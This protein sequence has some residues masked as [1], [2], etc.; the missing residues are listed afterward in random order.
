VLNKDWIENRIP[1]QGNMCLLHRVIDWG[2]Q[3]IV[4]EG[5]SHRDKTNPLRSNGRLGSAIGVEYAAQAMAI[6][7][8]LLDNFA[9]APAVGYLTSL[10]GLTLFVDRLDDCSGP[11]QIFAKRLTGDSQLI[12]YQFE[13]HHQDRCLLEGRASVV[14]DVQTA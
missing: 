8:A 10:R 3:H 9:S 4:C 5:L 6:H 7:G 11:L 2:D 12:L 14:M 13:I 1:H